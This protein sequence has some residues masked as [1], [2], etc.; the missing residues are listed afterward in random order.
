M[1]DIKSMATKFLSSPEGQK[2]IMEFL[3]SSEGQAQLKQFIGS[4]EGKGLVIQFVN[5]TI[6]MLNLDENTQKM[7][8]TA[9]NTVA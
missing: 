4:P 5:Q 7:I 1:F 2:M 3:T 6:G 8:T 9:L